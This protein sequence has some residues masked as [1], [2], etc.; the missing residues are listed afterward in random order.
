MTGAARA[1]IAALAALVLGAGCATTGES[2]D[3]AGNAADVAAALARARPV[4]P[5]PVNGTGHAMAFLV[6]GGSDGARLAAFDLTTR[7]TL[8]TRPAEIGGRVEVGADAIVHAGRGG[9][10]LVGRDLGSGAVLWQRAFDPGERLL[11]YAADDTLVVLTI[12]RSGAELHGGPGAVIGLEARSGAERW[13]RELGTGNVGAPAARG[14]LVAV[15]EQS[16]Y[17]TLLDAADG[18]ELGRALSNQESATFVRALSE[19]FAFGS[20]GVFLLEPST[21]AGSRQSPGYVQARLPRF[22]RPFYHYDMYRP[23]QSDYSA[24]DRNR[25]LWRLAPE[26]EKARF[27]SGLVT[28]HNYRFFFGF[29]AQSGELRWAYNQPSVDAVSSDHTGRAIVFVTADGQLGALD[30]TTGR[31]VYSAALPGSPSVRGATFDAD[32]FAP[33]GAGEPATLAGVLSSIVWDPD[34]RFSDVKVFAIG[35]MA[36]LPASSVTADLLKVL[37]AEGLPPDAYQ[38]AADALVERRDESAMSQ[39]VAAL[40]VHTD[41]AE[42]RHAQS[43]ATLAHAAAVMKARPMAPA[44]IDHLRLPDTDPPTAAEIARALAAIG[45]AGAAL[46]A[47]RAYLSMYRAD[48]VFEGD[49]APLAAVGDAIASLGGVSERPYLTEVADDKSTLA[50]LRLALKRTLAETEEADKP[51]KPDKDKDQDGD[52]AMPPSDAGKAAAPA[53]E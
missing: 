33:D 14:G 41:F 20:R 45:D 46:P 52:K 42:D 12:Q 32:G 29:D 11:G 47:L 23:E 24:I 17:V 2:A 44:L 3:R 50:A 53:K 10:S 16:Q 34:R 48:P 40:K 28:V 30:A 8:W 27:R 22:V 9:A 31:R 39:Y 35:E 1:R 37:Q 36:K 49:P 19:G 25:I 18:H 38:K 43:V 7:S 21:A 5:G 4:P 26:G 15:L 13:R 6:L 51:D